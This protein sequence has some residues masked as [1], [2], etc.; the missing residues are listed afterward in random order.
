[1]GEHTFIVTKTCPVC[2]ESTRVIKLKSRIIA[3]RTD[4]DFCVHYKDFNPYFYHIW[5]CE[6]C[7]F[8]ADEKH[9]LAPMPARHKEKMLTFL[10]QHQLALE[11]TETRGVPE[12]VASYKLAIFYA[13]MLDTTL[14]H[15]A[16][17]ELH[18]AWVYR[19]AGDEEHER[20]AMEHAAE[21]YDQS[22]MKEN[23]PQG[24]MTDNMVVY[25][26]GAIYYRLGNLEKATQYL[27]RIIGD[28]NIRSMEPK[29][30]DRARDLWQM[31]REHTDESN[32]NVPAGN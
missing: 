13:G 20:E 17:L 4:E 2:G 31:V 6:H 26:I 18:L 11:F 5:F 8:A 9:F 28:N 21:L 30:F 3:E 32:A 22:L 14:A 1:M 19:D 25:L 7:G 10:N 27:S 24:A 29:T 12:A 23:Y 15:R 16:G